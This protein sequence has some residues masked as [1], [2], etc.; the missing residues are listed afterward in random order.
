MLCVCVYTVD[1]V[2]AGVMF[3]KIRAT[4]GLESTEPLLFGEIQ[5]Q[6]PGKPRVTT[7]LS[8]NQYI[9]M[10]CVFLFKDALL[11]IYCRFID[12]ELIA[13]TIY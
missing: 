6:V 4:T 1:F 7:L 10:L 13:D 2:F 12:I 8:A 9:T 5:G 3:Y 11:N